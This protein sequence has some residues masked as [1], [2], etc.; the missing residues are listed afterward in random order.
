MP[1]LME[2]LRQLF[3]E[4]A[5]WQ[6]VVAGL[7]VTHIVAIVAAMARL[8]NN[9]RPGRLEGDGVCRVDKV[10]DARA[11]VHQ[12]TA[13]MRLPSGT[14]ERGRNSRKA[15]ECFQSALEV[16]REDEYPQM[17]ALSP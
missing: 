10:A 9:R 5:L 17:F 13:W 4:A 11:L 7:N 2:S 16:Y 14:Q 8:W 12:G 3:A 6:L 1:E 15:V